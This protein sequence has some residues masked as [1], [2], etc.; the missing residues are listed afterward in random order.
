MRIVRISNNTHFTG[1]R[2]ARPEGVLPEKT[3]TGPL[4]VAVTVAMV[5]PATGM[6]IGP[7]LF[8]KP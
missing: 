2:L 7:I 3:T 4:P 8:A 1:P 6:L 5:P